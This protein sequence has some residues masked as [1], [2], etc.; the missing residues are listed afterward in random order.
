MMRRRLHREMI[1]HQQNYADSVLKPSENIPYDHEDTLGEELAF[2]DETSVLEDAYVDL[3]D[4][5]DSCPK[6]NVVRSL[7]SATELSRRFSAK[8]KGTLKIWHRITCGPFPPQAGTSLTKAQ[9]I[10]AK[11]SELSEESS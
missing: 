11:S 8:V 2:F 1:P 7:Q 5:I 10:N 9:I 6:P 3:D 4:L